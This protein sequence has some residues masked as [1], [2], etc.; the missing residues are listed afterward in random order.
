MLFIATLP[1]FA[2]MFLFLKIF[3]IAPYLLVGYGLF[4]ALISILYG[5]VVALYQ[6][7]FKRLLAY[8]SMVH[9]G[10]ILCA[11]SLY[12]VES[13]SAAVLYLLIYIILMVFVFCFMF[14]L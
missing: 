10:F 4:I 6:V 7:S 9:M 11:L 2:Y 12:T 3:S 8:G 14:F 1:K 5:S 13:I